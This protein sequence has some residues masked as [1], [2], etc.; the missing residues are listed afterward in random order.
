MKYRREHDSD[1]WH[2]CVNCNEWPT[3]AG[4]YIEQDWPRGQRPTDGELDSKC[5]NKER[6]G[7]CQTV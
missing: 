2:W 1:T 5:L 6:A 4:T 3:Q 7:V